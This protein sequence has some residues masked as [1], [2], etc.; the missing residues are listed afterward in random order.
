M[1][2]VAISLKYSHLEPTRTDLQFTNKKAIFGSIENNNNGE[3]DEIGL[4][5]KESN[6]R[7]TPRLLSTSSAV[8][9]KPRQET[10]SYA[11]PPAHASRFVRCF[12]RRRTDLEVPRGASGSA[13]TGQCA[14]GPTTDHDPFRPHNDSCLF[15]SP[16]WNTRERSERSRLCFAD[17]PTFISPLRPDDPRIR[18]QPRSPLALASSLAPARPRR[19]S[20]HSFHLA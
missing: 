4:Q 12:V 13:L 9:A 20:P 5:W 10:E 2:P 1:E 7:M 11:G 3:R 8:R 6:G 17:R 16:P 18:S 14:W 19:V 15:V